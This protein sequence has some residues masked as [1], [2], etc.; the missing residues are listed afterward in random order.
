MSVG[1]P[2]RPDEGLRRLMPDEFQE[3]VRVM[4]GAMAERPESD[5]D[6]VDAAYRCCD[7]IAAEVVTIRHINRI[8][9]RM[10]E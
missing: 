4:I 8:K 3:A 2:G 5:P 7:H 9:A 6:I 1:V 10:R